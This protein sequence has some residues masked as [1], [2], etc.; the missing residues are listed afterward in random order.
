MKKY[1]INDFIGI[2]DGFISPETCDEGIKIFNSEQFFRQ[3]M[4]RIEL[5]NATQNRKKDESILFNRDTQNKRSW[6]FTDIINNNLKEA[7][8]IYFKQTAI[9]EYHGTE[10]EKL[11]LPAFKMQKTSP[12]GGYHVWHVE[13][14]HTIS[15]SRVLVYSIY[16]NDVVEGGETEFLFQKTRVPP[17]KG[18]ICIFPANFPYVHRGNPP[19]KEDKYI[20][21]SWVVNELGECN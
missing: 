6:E 17:V 20:I 1:I 16:L 11:I 13:Q 18:R 12:G 15:V 3:K 4:S 8:D 7:M 21:T 5:E 14:M 9:L 19:L 2:F 10:K